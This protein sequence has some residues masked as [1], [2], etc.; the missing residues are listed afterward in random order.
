MDSQRADPADGSGGV[1]AVVA[2][3][4]RELAPFA[5]RLSD[6]RR[7]RGGLDL[8]RG[9]LGRQQLALAVTGD[10]AQNAGQGLA[11]L[12]AT[13][14]VREVLV[15]GVSGALSPE[16]AVGSLVVGERVMD[17]AGASFSPAAAWLAHAER[18][19]HARRGV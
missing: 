14:A 1:T 19:T 17:E 7:V 15:I 3:M 4:G 13:V 8:I 9:R 12:F 11:E 18:Y 2:A 16:L 6:A 5:R 10:G